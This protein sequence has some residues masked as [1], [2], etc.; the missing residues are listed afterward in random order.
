M[1]LFKKT[2]THQFSYERLNI[3]ETSQLSKIQIVI[4]F[5]IDISKHV[6]YL[7]IKFY[8]ITQVS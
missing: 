2:T 1:W 6:F 5:P 3:S 8:N 7:V 4:F